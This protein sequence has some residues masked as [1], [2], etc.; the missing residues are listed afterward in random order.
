MTRKLASGPE[1]ETQ[2]E[3]VIAYFYA[4]LPNFPALKAQCVFPTIDVREIFCQGRQSTILRPNEILDR[5]HFNVF[6]LFL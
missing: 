6:A 1:I 4:S 5:I 2:E 3:P